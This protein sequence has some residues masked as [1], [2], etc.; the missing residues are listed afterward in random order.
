METGN[1]IGFVT[2]IM[3]YK[4]L[5]SDLLTLVIKDGIDGV[6]KNS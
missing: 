1:C 6:S 5:I 3:D 2:L 4:L